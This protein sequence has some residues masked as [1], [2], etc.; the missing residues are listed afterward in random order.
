MVGS[1]LSATIVTVTT[2]RCPKRGALS[3]S[4]GGAVGL[5]TMV[6]QVETSVVFCMR[7][8][9]ARIK[10]RGITFRAY[11]LELGQSESKLNAHQTLVS[12]TIK[13][14]KEKGRMG[15][16]YDFFRIGGMRQV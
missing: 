10:T 9:F 16:K 1:A 2:T 14:Y 3:R 12:I 13:A 11:R 8:Y 4:C 6:L 15:R 5:M 7:I